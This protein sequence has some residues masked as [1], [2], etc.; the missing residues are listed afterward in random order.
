MGLSLIFGKKSSVSRRLSQSV[1][2]ACVIVS[3]L[4]A[5]ALFAIESAADKNKE[6]QHL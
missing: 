3:M 5:L 4:F 2:T 1:L 6:E